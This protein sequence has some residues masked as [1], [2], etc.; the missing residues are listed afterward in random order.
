M[1]VGG[2]SCVSDVVVVEVGE[3]E[4]GAGVEVVRGAEPV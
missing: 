4:S 1:L 3:D 2:V